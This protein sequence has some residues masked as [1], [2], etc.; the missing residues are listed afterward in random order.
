MS[1]LTIVDIL[2]GAYFLMVWIVYLVTDAIPFKKRLREMEKHTK[3]IQEE[4]DNIKE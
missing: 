1:D 2:V 3:K 4:I